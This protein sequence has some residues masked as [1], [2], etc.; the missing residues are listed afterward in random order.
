[1]S[2]GATA[3]AALKTAFPESVVTVRY[4]GNNAA[5][6]GTISSA[7]S[8]G[9]ERIRA[10]TDEGIID[11][12]DGNVRYATSDEPQGWATDTN[13]QPA[14]TGQVIEVKFYGESNWVRFR[15]TSRKPLEGAARLNIV[16]EFEDI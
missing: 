3:I 14:I 5:L 12:A 11:G 13:G 8:A 1:M 7:F 6:A 15:V 2:I 9:V 4:A 10:S 16:A